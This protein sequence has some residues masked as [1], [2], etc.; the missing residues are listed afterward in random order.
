ML[1]SVILIFDT[2]SYL[3]TRE[4]LPLLPSYGR[5]RIVRSALNFCKLLKEDNPIPMSNTPA[6]TFVTGRIA[7]IILAT[8][9]VIIAVAQLTA[10][11]AALKVKYT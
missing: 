4:G 6:D 9:A 2:H 11:S 7:L 8:F 5:C 3:C 1:S 10:L